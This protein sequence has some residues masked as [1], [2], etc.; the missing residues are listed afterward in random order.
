MKRTRTNKV[1][2]STKRGVTGKPTKGGLH[3]ANTQTVES[4]PKKNPNT[5]AP[6]PANASAPAATPATPASASEDESTERKGKQPTMP[7]A[8]IY[9]Q[10]GRV[11][12]AVFNPLDGTVYAETGK[13]EGSAKGALEDSGFRLSPLFLDGPQWLTERLPAGAELIG[14]AKISGFPLPKQTHS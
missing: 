5:G 12:A 8:I 3:V 4:A 7:M 9:R 1:L 10:N 6:A 14:Y 13:G 11:T 2:T